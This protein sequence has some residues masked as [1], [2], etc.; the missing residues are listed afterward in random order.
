MSG[1]NA[2]HAAGTRRARYAVIG[3]AAVLAL[4]ASAAIG[5]AVA[6][7]EP[8]QRA[9]A[10]SKYGK[11]DHL[12]AA[13]SPWNTRIAAGAPVDPQSPAIVTK[14][15]NAPELI[16][17]L[18]LISY[19]QPFYTATASTPKVTLGGDNPIGAIPLDPA[20]Q[21]NPG[22]DAKLNV[23]D[24][25][26]HTIY[27][28]QGYEPAAKKVMWAVKHDYRTSLA[29]GYPTEGGPE[30]PTG[31]GMSQSAGTIRASD[32]ESGSID[33][34]LSFITSSPIA[35]FRYPASHSDGSGTGVGVQEGM[36]IQLD[37]SVEVNEIHGLTPGERMI[38]KALQKYGAFCTDN[39]GG[40]N[41]AMGFYIEKPTPQTQEIY[42][43]A[44][45]T[46]DWQVLTK[47][48]R[49]KLRVL[50]TS[51]TPRP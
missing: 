1:P 41:M 2:D 48:P 7:S 18:P 17:N 24:P 39:G 51:A 50:A 40:N 33:H 4:A 19:G 42:T 38:A 43:G 36:R 32:L 6:K 25:T 20:W 49:D 8:S 12:F 29:D 13:S 14:V 46:E 31:S 37:P 34:A 28:L 47:I 27:E 3:S 26:T 11:P 23:I 5:S 22:T 30:G 21:P 44:G 45:L 10:S 9:T 16:L 35:G 15:L